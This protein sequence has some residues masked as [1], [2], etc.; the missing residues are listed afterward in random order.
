M[1]AAA[2]LHLDEV[3]PQMLNLPH[4]YRS[5]DLEGCHDF[6]LSVEALARTHEQSRSPQPSPQT[7]QGSRISRRN[8]M[9]W[10]VRPFGHAIT[11]TDQ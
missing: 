10:T 7:R 3:D 1:D 2:I 5:N 6:L 8:A 9:L 11:G 4:E